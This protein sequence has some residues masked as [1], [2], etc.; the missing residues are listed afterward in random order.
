MSE[1]QSP[2]T[3]SYDDFVRKLFNRT[4]DNSKDF[5]HAILGIVTEVHELLDAT[6]EVN[7][8][9][10]VGDLAFYSQALDQ[11]IT[12]IEGPCTRSDE[13]RIARLTEYAAKAQETHISHVLAK[14]SASL[15][16]S[17][18]R[19]IG[20]GKMPPSLRD[21]QEDAE[22]FI[23]LVKNLRGS[24]FDADRVIKANMAKL[25]KRYPGGE[26]DAYRAVV[27]DLEAERV[28]LQA[29]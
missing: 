27:R 16:D 28:V 15:L 17:A 11:V 23:A 13:Q 6:D 12:E 22:C 8:L 24:N 7:A 19:W 25:L 9:E 3:P 21:T 14:L 26:F 2:S 18:K 1:N 5:A 4:G 10:E 29:S 20:Y